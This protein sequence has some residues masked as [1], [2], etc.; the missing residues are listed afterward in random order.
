MTNVINVDFSHS[1]VDESQKKEPVSL[2]WIVSKNN[3]ISFDYLLDDWEKYEFNFPMIA[4]LLSPE[5]VEKTVKELVE[6]KLWK[7]QKYDVSKRTAFRI[8]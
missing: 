3:N 1:K 4:W 6:E 8:H 2:R 5:D 7:G